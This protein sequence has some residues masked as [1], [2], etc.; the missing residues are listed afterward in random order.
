MPRKPS[1]RRDVELEEEIRKL[2]RNVQNKQ[3]RIRMKTGLETEG[4]QTVRYDQFNSRKEIEQYKKNMSTFLDKKA[5]FGVMTDGGVMLE[6]S[7]V[8]ELEK[9]I[10]K[11][12]KR[13]TSEFDKIKDLPFK[14]RGQ[15]TNITVGQQADPEVGMGDSRFSEFRGLSFNPHRFESNR[16]LKKRIDRMDELY[17]GNFVQ[18]KQEFL[19]NNYLKGMEEAGLL[20]M[21]KGQQI[22]TWIMEMSA[23]EFNTMF[24]TESNAS[25]NFLYEKIA[26]KARLEELDHI[27]NPSKK[28][29]KKRG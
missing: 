1:F 24:Y 9:R 5:N 25:I 11:V 21:R 2:N 8:R 13:K 7:D 10:K 27:W 17:K 22:K 6:Y 18:R 3:S 29:K 4:F 15:E 16:E 28:N 19:R 20:S 26:K 12:N 23:T 14:V